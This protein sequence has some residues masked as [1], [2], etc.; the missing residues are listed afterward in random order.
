MNAVR[1]DLPGPVL[2]QVDS[3]VYDSASGMHLLVPQGARLFGSYDPEQD[4]GDQ[5]V[6]IAW[7]RLIFPDGSSLTLGGMKGL[8]RQGQA[9]VRDQVH[10][11]L[12]RIYGSAI[13]LSAV[14]AGVALATQPREVAGTVVNVG[15]QA[16]LSPQDAASREVALNLGRTLNR[17]LE[18][19]IDIQPTLVIRAGKRM[20]LMVERDV[21]FERPWP[22]GP[23]DPRPPRKPP[24]YHHPLG[25]AP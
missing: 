19:S 25:A 13:L 3:P 23:P 16:S 20:A 1:S 15:G 22:P 10:R 6:G 24:R 8:D 21:G 9:G 14:S 17:Q 7:E 5:R 4:Y 11:H 18:R 2:A 12:G